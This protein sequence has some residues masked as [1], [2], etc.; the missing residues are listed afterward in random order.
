MGGQSAATDLLWEGFAGA[1]L[2][3]LVLIGGAGWAYYIY[4]K[5]REFQ[6]RVRVGVTTRLAR[7]EKGPAR[8]FVRLHIVNE[9]GAHIEINARLVLFSVTTKARGYPTFREIGRDFPM[10]YVYGEVLDDGLMGDIDRGP[11]TD[12]AMEPLECIETEVLFCPHPLPA[13]MAVRASIEKEQTPRIWWKPWKRRSLGVTAWESF[14]Y[15][16]PAAVMG[17]EYVALTQ[18]EGGDE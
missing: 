18:H 14:A 6:P 7:P 12:I 4:R 10:D 1:V 11:V 2:Q 5:R 9:S 17:A 13:L 3:A 8:L 15:V 16:D